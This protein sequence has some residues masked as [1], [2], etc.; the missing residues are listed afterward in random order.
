MTFIIWGPEYFLGIPLIDAQHEKLFEVINNYHDSEI[1][2]DVAFD[3]LIS[4]INFHFKTEEY[5]F[6]K[7]NYKFTLE[8]EASHEYYKK[9]IMQLQEKYLKNRLKNNTR[10]EIEIFVKEWISNHIKLGDVMYKMCFVE[11]GL[12]KSNSPLPEVK[13]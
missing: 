5:Y 8:H 13:T 9:T 2:T 11:H 10:E 12:G 7:F 3:A 1:S 6:E 4:Y